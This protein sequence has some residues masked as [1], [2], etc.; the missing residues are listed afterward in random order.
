MAEIFRDVMKI[1]CYVRAK[2]ARSVES[3]SPGRKLRRLQ[4]K[5]VVLCT[6]FHI[7]HTFFSDVNSMP[8]L[9]VSVALPNITPVLEP[10]L[11]AVELQPGWKTVSIFAR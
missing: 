4:A 6:Y 8:F 1:A 5:A 7:S 11:N 10:T 3:F 2:P 9:G